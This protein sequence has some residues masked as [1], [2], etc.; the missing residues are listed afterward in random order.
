MD[1]ISRRQILIGGAMAGAAA[2]VGRPAPLLATAAQPRTRINFRVPSGACDCHVHVFGDP[3]RYPFVPGRVYTPEPASVKEMQSMLKAID[4]DR[5]V[6][7][8]PSVYGTDNRCT[9]DA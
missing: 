3:Q 7:V 8:Q 6:V 1:K 2:L 9:L 5:V 4:M